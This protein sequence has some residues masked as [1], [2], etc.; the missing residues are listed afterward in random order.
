MQYASRRINKNS[1]CFVCS[2]LMHRK[3]L[4][5]HCCDKTLDSD[6]TKIVSHH[7]SEKQPHLHRQGFWQS[8]ALWNNIWW[9]RRGNWPS[10]SCVWAPIAGCWCIG[11]CCVGG[12]HKWMSAGASGFWFCHSRPENWTW[13]ENTKSLGKLLKC[14]RFNQFYLRNHSTWDLCLQPG[15]LQGVEFGLEERLV[16]GN[17]KNENST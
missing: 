14:R 10:G 11:G 6:K 15:T 3:F 7:I 1:F 16:E 2:S 9:S 8:L 4:K 12:S 13:T 5:T 17:L